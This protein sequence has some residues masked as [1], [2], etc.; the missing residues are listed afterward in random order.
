MHTIRSDPVC[1]LQ[2]R[3][4]YQCSTVQPGPEPLADP[5]A[6]RGSLSEAHGINAIMRLWHALAAHRLP[7]YAGHDTGVV[8]VVV[9]LLVLLLPLTTSPASTTTT[10]LCPSQRPRGPGPGRAGTFKPKLR[11]PQLPGTA[12][13]TSTGVYSTR[14]FVPLRS[15]RL[16]M[17]FGP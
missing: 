15:A 14:S 10:A 13:C 17:H 12:A 7:S 1:I 8:L 4:S 11:V 16:T 5:P 2:R 9:L 6:S 3:N